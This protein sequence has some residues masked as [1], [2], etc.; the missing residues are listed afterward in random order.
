M[1][2]RTIVVEQDN[3]CKTAEE[4]VHQGWPQAVVTD[5][6]TVGGRKQQILL[7]SSSEGQTF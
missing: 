6:H 3:S 5:Y 7:L 1:F 4:P 2:C